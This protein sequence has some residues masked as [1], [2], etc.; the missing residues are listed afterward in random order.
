MFLQKMGNN[1]QK[2]GKMTQKTMKRQ[3]AQNKL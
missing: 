3:K 2:I 1:W